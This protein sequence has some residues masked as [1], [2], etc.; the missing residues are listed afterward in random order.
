M[1][2]AITENGVRQ[3]RPYFVERVMAGINSIKTKEEI[4]FESILSVFRPVAVTAIML[5][6]V[7]LTYNFNTNETIS[8]NAA[9]NAPAVS[10]EDA[11]DP[12]T[13]LSM[14]N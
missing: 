9:L 1:R 8:V 3:F 7:L 14:E 10:I 2:L 13:A 11:F 4:L 5:L 6:I 12:F